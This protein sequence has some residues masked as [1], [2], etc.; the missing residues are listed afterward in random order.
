MRRALLLLALAFAA[1]AGPSG[2]IRPQAAAPPDLKVFAG[3]WSRHGTGVTITP[4]GSLN[5]EWRTYRM[6]GQDPPPCDQIV[7]SL[8]VSGGRAIGTMHAVAARRASGR[9]E[10]STDPA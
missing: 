1:C 4:D 10:A 6:C 7:N 5:I 3:T 2:A 8:I 9:V